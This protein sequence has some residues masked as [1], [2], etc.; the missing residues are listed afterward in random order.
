MKRLRFVLAMILIAAGSWLAWGYFAA[1]DMVKD[2]SDRLPSQESLDA[3]FHEE[4]EAALNRAMVVCGRLTTLQWN[5][6]ARMLRGD[7][8]AALAEHCELI[9]ARQRALSGP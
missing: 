8:I 9:E 6:I 5:P 4:T 2:I 1:Q 7:E 3:M